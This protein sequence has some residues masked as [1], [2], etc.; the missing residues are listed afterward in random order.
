L[1]LP[2]GQLN[3]VTGANG[4]GKSNVYR[5]LVDAALN[6]VVASLAREGGLASTSWAGPETIARGVHQGTYAVKRLSNRKVWALKLGFG[7][8][9]YGFGIDLGCPPPPPQ[10]TMFGPDP[11]LKRG[12]IGHGPIY[13]KSAALV[14][15][16]GY[17][18][19]APPA[20]ADKEQFSDIFQGK[21]RVFLRHSLEHRSQS[22]GKLPIVS[23][24]KGA[25][26]RLYQPYIGKIALPDRFHL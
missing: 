8:D 23:G 13:R 14:D 7:G 26:Y 16:N 1:S 21:K 24:A 3:V 19:G 25:K 10:A 9:S 11:H 5:S 12:C 17:D 2:L 22:C 18:G 15:R 4:S 20:S 6:C